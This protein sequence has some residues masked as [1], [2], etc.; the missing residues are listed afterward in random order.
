MSVQL[1]NDGSSRSS[2]A[3]SSVATAVRSAVVPSSTRP[4]QMRAMPSALWARKVGRSPGT[5]PRSAATRS[6]AAPIARAS[7][8]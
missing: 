6:A 2:G 4:A 8:A 3:R 1:C 5:S 7:A